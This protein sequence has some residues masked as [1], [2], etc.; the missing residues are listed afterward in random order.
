MLIVTVMGDNGSKFIDMCFNSII[1]ADKIIFCWG[2][3]DNKTLEKFNE[4]K[5]KYPEKFVLIQNSYNQEDKKMNGRQRNFY[6]D[7]LKNNYPDDW[8]LSLDLDEVVEN[9]NEVKRFINQAEPGVYSPKMRHLIGDLSHE[10]VTQEI[11]FVLNRLFKISE[12]DKYPE[13]EHPILLQKGEQKPVGVNALVIWHLA[14]INGMFDI[15]KKYDNHM[16]KSQIHSKEFLRGWYFNHLFGMYPK[17]RFNIGEL[18]NSILKEFGLP[19]DEIYF[20][21][22][23]NMETKHY[24]DAINWK[25]FFNP[26]NAIIFGCG[27]G[28]RV[29]TLNKIGVN[30]IG[31]E[32]SEYAVKQRLHENVKQGDLT[33]KFIIPDTA[34]LVVAF[35]V[36]EHLKYED[37]DKAIDNLIKSSKKSILISVPVIGNP[38]LYI[39]TT[40]IIKESEEWWLEQFTKKGLKRIQTPNNFL[41]K[42]QVY[43]FEK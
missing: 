31:I 7:Y 20:I 2:K 5:N 37:L 10:D 6:L 22:R 24:Q 25:E 16:K 30:T 23:G 34:D 17:K 14:Y 26:K 4:W 1:E 38:A 29:Y 13:Q 43:I 28:P 42:E 8:N 41:Y 33:K 15:K 18:P 11:H 3:E 27:L 35:D 32:L 39:D 40:H 12:A 21:G 9:L 19:K 36:L